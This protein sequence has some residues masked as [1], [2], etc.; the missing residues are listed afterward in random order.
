MDFGF[1]DE[2]QALR[3]LARKI[4]TEKVSE[5]R[6]RAAEATGGLDE[7]LWRALGD[8]GLLGVALPEGSGGT[9]LGM[10]ELCLVIEQAGRVVAPAP[11]VEAIAIGAGAIAEHGSTAQRERWLPDLA[12]GRALIGCALSEADNGE[13][14]RPRVT[15][16]EAAGA[17]VLD[18]E[19]VAVALGDRAARLLLPIR[20]GNRVGLVLLDPRAPGVTLEPQ[21]ATSGEVRFRVILDGARVPAEDLVG[22]IGADARVVRAVCLRGAT[23]YCALGIGIAGR[24]LEMLAD[25]ALK[26]Q[27]FGKPI[28]LFQ[29]VAQRAADAY[30]DLEAMRLATWQ[31]AW[32]L[33]AGVEAAREVAVAKFWVSDGGAR[34]A[35]AAQHIHGG[36]G[37][38]KAYPL[39][40]YFLAAKQVELALGGATPQLARLGDLLA[41]TSD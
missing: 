20:I 33:G 41:G 10:V 37:F 9:S 3:E 12:A 26:R 1:T 7:A 23:A 34:V 29:A 19:K 8:A 39:W 11:L 6:L 32:R 4:F 16:R 13:P 30:I 38:D 2:Q 17:L 25:H 35:A 21:I 14:W 31:A 40:R 28:G 24:Q 36:I 18:G 22:E 27:Q 5:A 15:A